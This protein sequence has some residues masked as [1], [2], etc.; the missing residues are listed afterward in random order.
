[1][2]RLSSAT[3]TITIDSPERLRPVPEAGRSRGAELRCESMCGDCH[4]LV[5]DASISGGS[6]LRCGDLY[7]VVVRSFHCDCVIRRCGDASVP[8]LENTPPRKHRGSGC[9]SST[10]A[11]GSNQPLLREVDAGGAHGPALARARDAPGATADPLPLQGLSG[12]AMLIAPGGNTFSSMR[13]EDA[14]GKRLPPSHGLVS[15]AR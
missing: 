11:P 1:M 2:H 13:A 6:S 14:R 12:T 7:G 15:A 3:A 10:R 9:R 8:F 5:R 4:P